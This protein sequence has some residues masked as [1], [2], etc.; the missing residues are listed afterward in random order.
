MEILASANSGSN[1]EPIPAGTHVARAYSMVYLGTIKTD[2]QGQETWLPKVR[3][4]FELPLE[5]KVFK[6]ENGEQ[7]YV[8]SKEYT[9]SLADKANLR[10]DLE[11]WRGKKFTDEEIKGF[12]ICKLLGVPCMLSIIHTEKNGNVYA[13]IGNI[14]GLVKGMS[15]P[16]QVNPIFEFSVNEFDEDKFQHLPQFLQD[17]IKGSVEFQKM[18]SH[19]DGVDIPVDDDL[20]PLPF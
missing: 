17:K 2:F 14:S 8:I 19:P 12:D 13:N 1:Y 18:I 7:P 3:I 16:D 11:S 10:K 4:T 9:L 15:C 5:T 20:E 6:E